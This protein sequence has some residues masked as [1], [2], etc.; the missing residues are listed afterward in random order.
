MPGG[1]DF[2]DLAVVPGRFVRIGQAG[3]GP[4]SVGLHR[5]ACDF[6]DAILQ[7]G[8]SRYGSIRSEVALP[9]QA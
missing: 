8:P 5:P 1:E 6:N 9:V 2:D 7:I 3:A 4:G